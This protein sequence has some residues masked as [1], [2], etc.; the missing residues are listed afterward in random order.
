MKPPNIQPRP[1][2]VRG[3]RFRAWMQ[4]RSYEQVTR[5]TAQ[6]PANFVQDVSAIHSRAV[7]KETQQ[8]GIGNARLQPQSIKRP[9]SSLKQDGEVANNHGVTLPPWLSLCKVCISY[10]LYFTYRHVTNKL[11]KA[12]DCVRPVR[13]PRAG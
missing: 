13:V 6:C 2:S 10:K 1:A 3:L 5:L 7:V 11:V 12:D 9:L 4:V 8:G